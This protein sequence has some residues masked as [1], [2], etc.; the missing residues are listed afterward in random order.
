[1]IRLSVRRSLQLRP[2]MS[3][4]VLT[5]VFATAGAPAGAAP[6][7][8][9]SQAPCTVNLGIVHIGL[10]HATGGKCAG[11]PAPQGARGAQVRGATT[12]SQSGSYVAGYS[13]TCSTQDGHDVCV[14]RSGSHVST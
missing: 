6:L 8:V 2:L 3:A 10:R 1:M 5:A 4:G 13:R 11:T 12:A 14:A 9:P 7:A